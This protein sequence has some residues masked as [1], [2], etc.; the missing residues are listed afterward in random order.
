MLLSFFETPLKV[1]NIN[2]LEKKLIN[3]KEIFSR[4]GEI[5]KTEVAKITTKEIPFVNSDIEIDLID[6]YFSNHI[7]R[8]SFTMNECRSIKNKLMLTRTDG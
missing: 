5:P 1:N 7:A 4:V 3:S 2:E 6:Y 8:S